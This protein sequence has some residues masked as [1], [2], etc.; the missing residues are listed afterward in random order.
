MRSL[1]CIKSSFNL[2]NF[3]KKSLNCIFSLTAATLVS[4]VRSGLLV[5]M[6]RYVFLRRKKIIN[7]FFYLINK[8]KRYLRRVNCGASQN[9]NMAEFH[10]DYTSYIF[11]DSKRLDK[12]AA[13][14]D[15][16]YAYPT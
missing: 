15:F 16:H 13:L 9:V 12:E 8:Y 10:V 1:K 7:I 2:T 5:I 6:K 3:E 4:Y 14:L 11:C